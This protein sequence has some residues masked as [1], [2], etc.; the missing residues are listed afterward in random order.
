VRSPQLAEEVVQSVFTDLS[1]NACKLRPGTILAAWLYE[2]TRRKAIDVVR[3]ESRRQARERLAVEMAAMNTEADWSHIE[4]LLDEA[5]HALDDTDRAAVLLRYF[6]N[7][8]LREVGQTLGTSDD[9]AQKRV[10][11]AVERLREFFSK[12]GVTIGVGGLI[13]CVST[14]AVQAAPI[15]LSAA[16]CTAAALAGTTATSTSIAKPMITLIKVLIVASLAVIAVVSFPTLRGCTSFPHSHGHGHGHDAHEEFLVG[17]RLANSP[18]GICQRNLNRID[19]AIHM[20]A[21]ENKQP[22]GAAVTVEKILPYLGS[23]GLP[24]CPSGGSYEL[25]LVWGKPSCSINGHA[26]P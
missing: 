14:N 12:R 16:I 13:A 2:V 21:L 19:D 9:A 10:S 24:Q 26:L 15:G 25:G 11:R 7:K 1:Q 6:E 17:Q 23:S 5:M 20:Y 4:P 18:S 3:R 22:K 8:S